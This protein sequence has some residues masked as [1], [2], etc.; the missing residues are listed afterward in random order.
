[1]HFSILTEGFEK[2]TLKAGGF[3]WDRTDG[4]VRIRDFQ[5]KLFIQRYGN[6]LVFLV[7][8]YRKNPG[9]PL[10]IIME[11]GFPSIIKDRGFE[12]SMHM[13]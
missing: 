3:S 8:Q 4:A 7:G 6:N 5:A 1:M 13:A 12:S 2:R 9:S 10:F 11:K